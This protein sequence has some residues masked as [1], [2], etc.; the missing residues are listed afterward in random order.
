MCL[1][2]FPKAVILK[3]F[4]RPL[5]QTPSPGLPPQRCHPSWPNS[6]WQLPERPAQCPG[7]TGWCHRWS[8]HTLS[9]QGPCPW[10]DRASQ[11][12][13]SVFRSHNLLQQWWAGS[14][15]LLST[16]SDCLFKEWTPEPCLGMSLCRAHAFLNLTLVWA[17]FILSEKDMMLFLI[18]GWW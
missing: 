14:P 18:S 16:M 17:L 11:T 5:I 3:Y 12:D 7:C 13:S 10:K 1:A 2:P 8:S 4:Q 9:A 15:Y 6:G